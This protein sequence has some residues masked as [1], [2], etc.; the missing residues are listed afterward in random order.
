MR[1]I[2]HHASLSDDYSGEKLDMWWGLCGRVE[3]VRRTGLC[4]GERWK[5]EKGHR[6]LGIDEWLCG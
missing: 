1:L 6:K 5:D 3:M 4:E 2:R